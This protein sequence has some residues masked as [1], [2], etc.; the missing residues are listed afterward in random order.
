MDARVQL[1]ISYVQ[2]GG[3]PMVGIG[4]LKEV[5]KEDPEN[6]YAIWTLG[7]FSQQSGQH[8]KAI[9]RFE[10]LLNIEVNKEERVNAYTALEFSLISTNQVNRALILHEK[11]MEEFASDSTLVAMIQER[12]KEIKNRFINVQKD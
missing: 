7:T 2:G 11:M 12:N 8:E 9:Q 6:K 5:L 1:G 10:D 3:A 4:M